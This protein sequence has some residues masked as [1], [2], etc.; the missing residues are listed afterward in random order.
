MRIAAGMLA[1]IALLVGAPVASAQVALPG[2][3]AVQVPLPDVGGIEIPE[4]G[5]IPVPIAGGEALPA[6]G[7]GGSLIPLTPSTDD[8]RLCMIALADLE[9]V[10]ELV[11]SARRAVRRRSTAKRRSALRGAKALRVEAR[12]AKRESC[13]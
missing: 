12:A 9:A 7:D 10:R 8:T 4:T 6:P 13:L 1:T 5:V 11:R 3:D 2:T